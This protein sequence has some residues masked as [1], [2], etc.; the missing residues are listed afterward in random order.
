[1]GFCGELPCTLCNVEAMLIISD[2][3]GGAGGSGPVAVRKDPEEQ[4]EKERQSRELQEQEQRERL[5]QD[6]QRLRMERKEQLIQILK[7]PGPLLAIPSSLIITMLA[8]L[9]AEVIRWFAFFGLLLIPAYLLLP[10]IA[11]KP[12]RRCLGSDGRERLER[13]EREI[14]E[15]EFQEREHIKRERL[16]REAAEQERHEQERQKMRLLRRTQL[17]QLLKAPPEGL[18]LMVLSSFGQHCSVLAMSAER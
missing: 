13:L 17:I 16:E 5:E 7:A 1:M 11:L 8:A 4:E 3:E 15:L 10:P 2:L 9:V 12:L 6:Q 14:R 18:L